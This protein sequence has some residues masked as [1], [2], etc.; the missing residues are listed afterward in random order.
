MKETKD[1]ILNICE[2]LM[3]NSYMSNVRYTLPVTSDLYKSEKVA[4]LELI[5][6]LNML[7]WV[8]QT[9]EGK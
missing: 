2:D 8:L 7:T 1:R 5:D 6:E 3:E 4:A 9:E